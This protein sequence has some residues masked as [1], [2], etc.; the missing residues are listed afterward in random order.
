[1]GR[2][3]IVAPGPQRVLEQ[4]GFDLRAGQRGAKTSSLTPLRI[5]AI[6]TIGPYLFPHLVPALASAAPQM[7]LYIEEG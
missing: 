1:M 2:K 5:G 3:K 6:Y 4:S 7:P